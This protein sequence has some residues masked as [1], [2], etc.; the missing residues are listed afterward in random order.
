[1]KQAISSEMKEREDRDANV[2]FYG[3]SEHDEADVEIRR[4]KEKKIVKEIASATGV[5]MQDAMEVKFRLGRWDAARDK[6]R[7]L[8]VRIENDEKR[9]QLISNAR[10]L[11]S[12]DR[13][14][15][16]FINRDLTWAQREE[17]RKNDAKA[18][19]EA[20]SKSNSST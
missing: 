15:K 1:M 18:R 10:K 3:I 17:A 7:P 13:W 9:I 5:D 4:D 2:I 14:K 8:L 6:P 11:G 20:E 19:E 12:T 16:V